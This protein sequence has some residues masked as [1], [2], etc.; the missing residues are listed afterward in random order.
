[1]PVHQEER[2][3][4]GRGGVLLALPA[5]L[6]VVIVLGVSLIGAGA[7]SLGL[8]P[9]VGEPDPGLQAWSPEGDPLAASI[10]V[11][12]YIAAVSTVLSLVTGFLIAAYILARPR[13]GRL[14]AGLSVATIPIPHLIGAG[15]MGLLLSDSGFLSRLL[16]LPDL[17]PHLV[18]GSW[19]IAT[20]AEYVWKES[21]FV[22]LVVVG[23]MAGT[24]AGLCDTAASLGATGRQ[25]ILHVV[26]P[27]ARPALAVSALIIFVYTLGAYEAP[28]LL[29]PTVPEPLPVRSVR[30][31]GSIDLD[32]RPEAM[33]SALLA[34][35]VGLLAILA[36]LALIRRMRGMR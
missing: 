17:F 12:I 35:A 6:P 29:G 27:L 32:A 10:F 1:M 9:F 30:L 22:A 28:W 31:F 7:Q 19:W 20:I 16:G 26:L 11:S 15:A 24:T 21:A 18:G 33:A 8:L 3:S 13:A 14:V 5:V 36:G 2:V 23:S 4:S 25:R 34:V